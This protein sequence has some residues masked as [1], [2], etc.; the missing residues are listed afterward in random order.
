MPSRRTAV[1]TKRPH[2]YEVPC[3][4]CEDEMQGKHYFV[5]D[6]GP[7]GEIRLRRI[8]AM[9]NHP[10]FPKMPPEEVEKLFGEAI[11]KQGIA[12]DLNGQL[13]PSASGLTPEVA[14]VLG[15]FNEMLR[16][17]LIDGGKKRAADTKPSWKVD[18]SHW[19]AI[20]SHLNKYMH[21]EKVDKDSG[22]HP[23]VHLACRALMIAFQET[24][25]PRGNDR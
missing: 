17:V 5:E 16:G 2:S 12:L 19:P 11:S 1:A 6:L 3:P 8:Q 4:G 22:K 18:Q 15:H 9:P 24:E 20:F 23:L 7:N 13:N 25:V 14:E 21:G 10:W